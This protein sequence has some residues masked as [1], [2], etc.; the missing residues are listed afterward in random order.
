MSL[1]RISFIYTHPLPVPTIILPYLWQA[2]YILTL[3]EM[4]GSGFWSPC[5]SHTLQTG[6]C[7]PSHCNICLNFFQFSDF[8]VP[9]SFTG[10]EG[11]WLLCCWTEVF[12]SFIF[13]DTMCVPSV[14]MTNAKV[15]G[16]NPLRRDFFSFPSSP[17]FSISQE[18]KCL[19]LVLSDDVMRAMV[20][21][22]PTTG[23]SATL[24]VRPLP[25]NDVKCSFWGVPKL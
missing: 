4:R 16:L 21:F 6:F 9:H 10:L 22:L 20:A 7:D 19:F 24:L 25:M 5:P 11:R 15:R 14:W 18:L 13:A 3:P 17:S 23:I 12:L 1:T 2:T 8:Y